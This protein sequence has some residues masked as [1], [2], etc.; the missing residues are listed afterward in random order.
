M[1]KLSA[2]LLM[3]R[4]RGDAL[5]VF[6]VHPGGPFWAKKDLGAWSIPKGE[7]AEGEDAL[8]T[9]Q[10]EFE[11][12]TSIA[13]PAGELIQLTDIKQP[14][15]KIV[16]AWAIEGD[17][18]ASSVSSNMFSMEWPPKSGRSQEFPEI[19]RGDW[20]P[21]E[22]A[23]LKLLKGQS[24]FLD[25]L[26]SKVGYQFRAASEGELQPDRSGDSSQGSLFDSAPSRREEGHRTQ[27]PSR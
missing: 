27:V 21:I 10:R 26:A 18:D 24:G 7:Y 5:E 15:G 16:S 3:F 25:E 1:A 12:E 23:R 22:T 11:E 13:P 8:A 20:F 2:G 4:W 14:S 9:A 19:D 17:C 6:I